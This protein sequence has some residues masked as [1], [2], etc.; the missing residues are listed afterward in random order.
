MTAKDEDSDVLT[1]IIYKE[2]RRIITNAGLSGTFSPINCNPIRPDWVLPRVMRFTGYTG[3]YAKPR[4]AIECEEQVMMYGN[5]LRNARP[6][7][8]YM[9]LHPDKAEI[10]IRKRKV[11]SSGHTLKHSYE[12]R[13]ILYNSPDALMAIKDCIYDT[14]TEYLKEE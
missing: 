12:S 8:I 11:D 5:T 9:L 10:F 13:K 3:R 6:E 7:I 14:I 2:V 4:L 1:S